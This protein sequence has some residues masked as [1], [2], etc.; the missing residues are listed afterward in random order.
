MTEFV[1]LFVLAIL[2]EALVNLTLGDVPVW[3]WVKKVASMILGIAFCVLWKVGLISLLGIEGGIPLV[4]YI[5]TGI[6][7]SRGANY[8]N[9]LLTRLKGGDATTTVTTT[10]TT[11]DAST[12]TTTKTTPTVP[13]I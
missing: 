12:T 5:A 3:G 11:S 1:I 13:P 4:D 10:P 8:L 7:I 6:I 2:V 9:Q